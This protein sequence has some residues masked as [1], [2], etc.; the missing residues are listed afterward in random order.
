[1]A[2]EDRDG[3]ARGRARGPGN[4]PCC[5]QPARDGQGTNGREANV[6]P[7]GPPSPDAGLGVG[8]LFSSQMGLFLQT[9]YVAQSEAHLFLNPPRAAASHLQGEEEERAALRE[10]NP[11]AGQGGPAAPTPP[12]CHAP[13]LPRHLPTGCWDL[14]KYLLPLPTAGHCQPQGTCMPVRAPEP[15]PAQGVIPQPPGP[16]LKLLLLHHAHLLHAPVC[17]WA[18][19]VLQCPHQCSVSP[20][21]GTGFPIQAVTLTLWALPTTLFTPGA[22][23]PIL[24]TSELSRPSPGARRHCLLPAPQHWSPTSL[25]TP[26]AHWNHGSW[27]GQWQFKLD[28]DIFQA[29]HCT[30]S[31]DASPQHGPRPAGP[32]QLKCPSSPTS[33]WSASQNYPFPSGHRALAHAIPVPVF[34]FGMWSP[35]PLPPLCRVTVPSPQ[36]RQDFSR[37]SLTHARL[38]WQTVQSLTDGRAMSDRRTCV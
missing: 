27:A 22:P 20:T 18:R 9:K 8:R 2:W 14:P 5:G 21:W 24:V 29:E 37:W 23:N 1:V 32:A 31:K 13:P 30:S 15:S 7:A 11:L 6:K 3:S 35:P 38:Y 25:R 28:R 10:P 19:S 36:C 4:K 26:S 33:A 34:T 12:G 16:Q 17:P